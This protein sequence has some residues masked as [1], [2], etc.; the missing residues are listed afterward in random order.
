MNKNKTIKYIL[1]S[2]I[3][4]FAIMCPN[5][6]SAWN[7]G[8]GSQI[9]VGFDNTTCNQYK[10]VGNYNLYCVNKSQTLNSYTKN[11]YAVRQVITII[12]KKATIQTPTGTNTSTNVY[13]ARMAY[14]LGKEGLSKT[15]GSYTGGRIYYSDRQRAVYKMWD[16]WTR[17]SGLGMGAYGTAD[18][19][20]TTAS[21]NL[22]N[23]AVKYANTPASEEATVTSVNGKTVSYKNNGMAIGP[24]KIKYTGNKIDKITVTYSDGTKKDISK[25]YTDTDCIC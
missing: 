11:T 20:Q 2:L 7:L 10:L 15:Y 19:G 8:L 4:M 14:V 1:F 22:Y 9:T 25:V 23:E 12:G 17:N 13:N 16:E 5:F 6:S 21:T 18:P 3:M 24:F